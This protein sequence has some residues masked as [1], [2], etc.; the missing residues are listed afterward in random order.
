MIKRKESKTKNII[1]Y[2]IIIATFYV[3][4]GAFSYI[5]YSFQI[6]VFFLT[7]LLLCI[8]YN[9]NILK[10]KNALS[11]LVIMSFF[12]LIPC[13]IFGDSIPTYIAIIM[14]LC[15]GFFCTTLISIENYK[16]KF[17]N[18]IVWFAFISLIGFV[19]GILKPSIA[20]K[21]PLIDTIEGASV[22]YYN[23]YMY[24]FMAAKGYSGF[25]LSMRNAGICWEPGCYQMF[26]NVALLFLLSTNK[27][28][29]NK[30]F[31]FKLLI[32][33]VTIIT[34][35]STTGYILMA[36]ILIAMRKT[37]IGN[38]L[39]SLSVLP[40]ILCVVIVSLRFFSA[41]EAIIEK[42][43]GEFFL[44]GSS[45]QNFLNRI[46]LECIP[47]IFTDSYFLG[48]GFSNWLTFDRSLW[49]SIIHS[50][51]CLGTPFTLMHLYG[52]LK[53]SKAL[54]KRY[55]VLFIIIVACASTET[56]FWRVLFNTFAFYGWNNY[57]NDSKSTQEQNNESFNNRRSNI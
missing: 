36:I 22:V 12:V 18:V 45:S 11:V 52:L 25:V 15:I 20:L 5:N 56:L 4:G 53:G 51:L 13:L 44:I 40:I 21:F 47:Y 14:Q 32:L 41:G 46:S 38:N 37:W 7:S 50:L 9:K 6:I 26:L 54:T 39:K 34:T 31:Y 1:E 2:A 10:H 24:V 3:T 57:K 48:M 23:A 43:K 42:L 30:Y 27:D 29:K 16:K 19:A 28:E 35:I 55:C 8:L 49:N 33:I 17:V